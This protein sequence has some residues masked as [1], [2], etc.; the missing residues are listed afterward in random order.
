MSRLDEAARRWGKAEVITGQGQSVPLDL[1]A[2]TRQRLTAADEG[3]SGIARE[4]F[5][6]FQA[7]AREKACVIIVRRTK[8][9]CLPWIKQDYPAKPA[10][11][12]KV[13]TN[14]ATGLV[15]CSRH[16]LGYGYENQVTQAWEAGYFVLERAGAAL[17]RAPLPDQ[18]R[19][20][21]R[22]PDPLGAA[23]LHVGV[24]VASGV[25][26]FRRPEAEV[27]RARRFDELGPGRFEGHPYEP[28]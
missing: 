23:G 6:V 3:L 25:R 12:W 5:P 7:T 11:V 24:D 13:K 8:P 15:T 28:G 16:S 20:T 2:W 9:A 26:V 17:E 27:L 4:H 21:L 10:S 22:S 18:V 14:A 1:S 19:P